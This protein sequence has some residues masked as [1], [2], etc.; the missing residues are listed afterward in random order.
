MVLVMGSKVPARGKRINYLSG[1]GNRTTAQ[2]LADQAP[3]Q[4]ARPRARG[5]GLDA[6]PELPRD[7]ALTSERADG[8][9]SRRAARSPAEGAQPDAA[10]RRLRAD[11]LAAP[12]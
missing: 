10:R 5:G 6:A 8:P 12:A 2:D 3:P 9:A 1:N 11:L 4:P 7:R